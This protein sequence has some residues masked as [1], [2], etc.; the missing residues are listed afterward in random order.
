[1]SERRALALVFLASGS[2]L[3]LEILAGRL[4]AP[5]VGVTLQTFTGIIGVVLA[6]IAVGTWQGGRAADRIDPARAIPL[7]LALGGAL[8]IA[9]VPLIRVLGRADLGN[10][11]FAIV[12]LATL[13]FFLPSAVLSAVSPMVVKLCLRS[14]EHTGSVVGRLSAAGTTGSLVG[15]FL[16]GFVFVAR[17]PITPVLVGVGVALVAVGG[18]LFVAHSARV[19]HEQDRLMGCV[20]LAVCATALTV[21]VP[22]PC[23]EDTTYY[24][25][26]VETDPARPTGRVLYLDDQRH[27]YVDLADPTHLE[28]SYAQ[29]MSDVI[30]AISP[31][32]APIASVHIG[33]GGFT[34]PRYLAATHPGSTSLVLEVDQGVVDLARH[35]LGLGPLDGLTIRTGDARVLLR[36]VPTASTR[37]VIGDAFG[38]EAVPWHLATRQMV[39]DVSRVLTDDGVYALNLIDGSA[40]RFAAAEVATLRAV[41]G[42]VAV[43]GPAARIDGQEGGNLVLVASR[44][45]LPLDAIAA[46][47]AA[48]GDT[49][50]V[51]GDTAGID[52]FIGD[53][54][55][56][57]DDFA[58]VD[59]LHTRAS[60]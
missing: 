4:L 52:R 15:V 59:Q 1:V 45:E 40:M 27:S 55:V 2:V 42:H 18:G 12:A 46:H 7:L 8:S 34:M 26:R 49:D 60:T 6:G 23:A 44:H 3:V 53:A 51:L 33:G 37:L 28:F 30:A 19:R 36:D 58:P 25:A 17:F 13:G 11:P 21:T 24:C 31:G 22:S 14:V 57:T 48:R 10:G 56:L 9:S 32:D 39:T 35:E 41:F 54:P 5:Y 47:V 50:Q 38:G 29:N 16:T 43:I 20:A